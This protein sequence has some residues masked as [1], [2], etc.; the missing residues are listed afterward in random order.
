[1]YD[2]LNRNTLK[3]IQRSL[4]NIECTVISSQFENLG[5]SKEVKVRFHFSK[6]VQEQKGEYALL[7]HNSHF[8]RVEDKAIYNELIK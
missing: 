1:M 5:Y 7:W 2:L 8:G 6:I 4:I 3:V